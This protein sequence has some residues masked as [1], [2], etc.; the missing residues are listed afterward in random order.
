MN[1]DG[2]KPEKKQFCEARGIR[3]VVLKRA[4][5]EGLPARSSTG[6]RGF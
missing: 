6:L 4:P 3:Y 1:E 2:D 5:K